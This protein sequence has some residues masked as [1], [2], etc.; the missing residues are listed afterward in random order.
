LASKSFLVPSPSVHRVKLE[1][2]LRVII[3]P[4][5]TAQVVAIQIW[6][7]VGSADETLPEGG[8][9]HVHEHMLFKGTPTR[10]VGQIA[11]EIEAAGGDINAW[12]SYDQTVY[13]VVLASEYFETGLDILSDAMMNSS[14]DETE[15][16]KEL[17][18]ILE[19]IKRSEDQPTSRVSRALFSTAF[20]KHPYSRPVI[21]H[22][23]VVQNFSRENVTNFFQDHYCAD[24]TTVVIVGDVDA[25]EAEAAVEK[26]LGNMR[27]GARPL[28]A[29]ATEPRQTSAR[30]CGLTDDVEETHLAL[31]WHCP[32]IISA[33]VAS[34]D[35]LSVILGQGESSRLYRRIKH[36][37]QTV[38]EIYAYAYTPK[39][40]G[41]FLIGA[42]LEHDQISSAMEKIGAELHTIMNHP[43]SQAEL[44]KAQTILCSEVIYQKETMEGMA[45]RMGFWSTMLGDPQYEERYQ[46]Q[47]R[48][49]RLED[50]QRVAR[51]YL[52]AHQANL[53]VLV[54]KA[55]PELVES[56]RLLNEVK[57]HLPTATKTKQKQRSIATRHAATCIQL[58]SGAR[59]IIQSDRT[60]PIIAV[61]SVWQGGLRRETAPIAGHSYLLSELLPRG[62]TKQ[63]AAEIATEIDAMAG[64]L[65]AFAGRNSIGFR[66][67]FLKESFQRGSELFGDCLLRPAFDGDELD[68]IQ[69]STLESLKNRRDNPSGLCFEIFQKTLWEKH[70]YRNDVLGTKESVMRANVDGLRKH[71][72]HLFHPKEAV[73]SI[74]GDINPD[75][76]I[77]FANATLPAEDDRP[78]PSD[79]WAPSEEI[80]FKERRVVRLERDRSQAHVILGKRGLRMNDSDRYAL[81]VLCAALSGQSG[82]LFLE[83]RDQQSL[84]YSVSAFSVEGIEPGSFAVYM[85]TSPDKVTQA[86]TGIEAT[87][88]SILENGIGHTELKRAQRYLIGTDSISLQRYGA[89]ASTMA[90]HEV[91]GMGFEHHR[92][93]ARR[94]ADVDNEDV[95]RVAQKILS[96]EGRVISIVAPE[97]TPGPEATYHPADHGTDGG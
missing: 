72:K 2:G 48:A 10:A 59:C 67:T 3:S 44:E 28:P 92:H 61:R 68:R 85:G 49:V 55:Y 76:A 90:F 65:E 70:P 26:Y 82:R 93:Y 36:E 57:Q 32:E 73:L 83:L 42:S 27:T 38:N 96:P 89:Q 84:C 33:D 4:N 87:L 25:E 14:F 63:N 53:V 51:T 39:D 13:H 78:V 94:I 7:G 66:G 17:E 12:T 86:I 18:V 40:Q 56:E 71:W 37:A 19:E 34:F 79:D 54:P 24:R 30:A 46:E 5:E 29:R 69:K 43:V 81:E 11:G 16:S 9:A 75:E 20:Q 60:H 50:L 80:G 21:G 45:R 6:V 8:L 95:L 15:L 88:D 47:I 31:G 74:V 52:N 77:A 22:S 62:T 23:E 1:N 41:L 97:G 58:D 91:Y 64:Q 35:V